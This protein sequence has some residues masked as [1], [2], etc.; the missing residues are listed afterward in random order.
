MSDKVSEQPQSEIA[1]NTSES[2]RAREV[3]RLIKECDESFGSRT[4]RD[5][6]DKLMNGSKI[7]NGTKASK[8]GRISRI[9]AER[10]CSGRTIPADAYDYLLTKYANGEEGV[11]WTYSKYML[12]SWVVDRDKVGTVVPEIWEE[13]HLSRG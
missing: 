1:T 4:S 10:L 8:W 5:E 11:S 13:S 3:L 7:P 2:D 12:D 9:Q 6:I